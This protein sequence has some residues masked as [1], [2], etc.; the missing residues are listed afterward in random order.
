MSLR[1]IVYPHV[2]FYG[3]YATIHECFILLLLFH[4][5]CEMD[6]TALSVFVPPALATSSASSLLV[7]LF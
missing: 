3:L 5:Y 2:V 4:F 6:P 1:S 7:H